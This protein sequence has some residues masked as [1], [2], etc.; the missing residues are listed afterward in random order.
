VAER[1][2]ALRPETGVLFMSGYTDE[3]IGQHGVLDQRTHFIQK[4]F[5]ADALLRKLRE[6]LDQRAGA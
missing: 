4:P 1:L 6:V 2:K 3:A 5:S